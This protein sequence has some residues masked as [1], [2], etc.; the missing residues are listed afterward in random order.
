VQIRRSLAMG[1]GLA[2]AMAMTV[3]GGPALAADP[4]LRIDPPVVNAGQGLIFT[5]RVMQD[6]AVPTSGA[7]ATIT[8]DPTILQVADVS[9][10]SDYAS[11]PIFLPQDL[12]AAIQKANLGGRLATVAAA[13]TPPGS[14]AA[15]PAEFLLVK[16]HVVGCGKTELKLPIGSVDAAMIDG[17]PDTYGNSVPVT[18][19]GAE[20]TTCVAAD[21]VTPNITR[22]AV[23][24][25]TTNPPALLVS[26]A[27]GLL[28]VGLL[29]AMV[30]RS[31]RREP[32]HGLESLDY[33]E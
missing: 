13:F 22:P 25:T 10:G 18:T 14:V 8:F 3:A 26:G 15:G 33:E 17:R 28:A 5:I 19:A 20:V 21:G 23:A 9:L 4:S 30:L 31:R 2:V 12:A 6:A 16:F 24:A 7:E 27:A 29:A 11:A 1:A 32:S